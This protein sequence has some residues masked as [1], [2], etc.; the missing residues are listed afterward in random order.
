MVFFVFFLAKVAYTVHVC[1]TDDKHYKK[2]KAKSRK[3]QGVFEVKSR[4]KTWQVRGIWSQQLEHKQVP[5]WGTEPGVRKGKCSLLACH[6]RCK[7]SLET[8]HNR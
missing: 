5:R 7:C 3:Y 1:M 4:V 8:T 6:T 2:F